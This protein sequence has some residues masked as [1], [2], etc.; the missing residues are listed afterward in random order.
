MPIGS[1]RS[2]KTFTTTRADDRVSYDLSSRCLIETNCGG[3]TVRCVTVQ[4]FKTGVRPPF[5]TLGM[6]ERSKRTRRTPR[7]HRT[8]GSKW[9]TWVKW[10]LSSFLFVLS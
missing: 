2:S 3:R 10:D 7:S 9:K 6:D 4:S 1:L 5:G 8:I